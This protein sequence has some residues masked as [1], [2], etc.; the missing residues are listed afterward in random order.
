MSNNPVCLLQ[1]QPCH[2]GGEHDRPLPSL[3]Q[4]AVLRAAGA[5][6]AGL[7]LDAHCCELI[8]DNEAYDPPC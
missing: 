3:L 6:E 7:R 2:I 8:F 4:P 1:L 5:E